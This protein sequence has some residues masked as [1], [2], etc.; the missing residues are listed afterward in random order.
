MLV[1]QQVIVL[2]NRKGLKRS[3]S[4]ATTNKGIYGMGYSYCGDMSVSVCGSG[5]NGDKMYFMSNCGSEKEKSTIITLLT[6]AVIINAETVSYDRR[7]YP[8]DFIEI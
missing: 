5:P 1:S 4:G 3:S 6:I 2:R 7:N 8:R